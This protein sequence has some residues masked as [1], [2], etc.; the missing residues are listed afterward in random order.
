M[1]NPEEKIICALDY[2]YLLDAQ[3][4]MKDLM[5]QVGMFKLGLSLINSV[6]LPQLLRAL[7]R[8]KGEDPGLTCMLD[9]KLHDIPT[10][11]RHAI[12][13]LEHYPQS[14]VELIT[15]HASSGYDAVRA[16]VEEA[17]LL[18][19]GIAAVTVLTSMPEEEGKLIYGDTARAVVDLAKLSERA[20]ATHIVCSPLEIEPVRAACPKMK[21]ITPG[22]RPT[23]VESQDQARRMTPSE[24][25]SAGVD[26]M[27]VGRPIT[28][29]GFT[30]PS[31]A[32]SMV[33]AEVREA[34]RDVNT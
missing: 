26:Y 28:R 8:M 33:L 27:V 11:H 29:P 1:L 9:L 22:I 19:I 15:V 12:R 13:A 4:V 3:L 10:T 25:I 21:I 14:G 17:G 2:D 34:L 24:A 18:G 31:Q 32:A 23:W 20:G 30:T 16:A 6:G 5:Y 7:S